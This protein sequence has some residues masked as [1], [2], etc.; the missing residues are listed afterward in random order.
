MTEATEKLLGVIARLTPTERRECKYKML[1]NRAGCHYSTVK[2]GVR[3]LMKHGLIEASRPHIRGNCVYRVELTE[4]G[5]NL[6]SLMQL[7]KI[8][9]RND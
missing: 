3:R 9:Y 5:R 7:A 1:S 6:V 8:E 4:T 2:R